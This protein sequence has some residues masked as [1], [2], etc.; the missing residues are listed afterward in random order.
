MLGDMLSGSG[1]RRSSGTDFDDL[2]I[3]IAAKI[4]LLAYTE[5]ARRRL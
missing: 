1:K 3:L 2:T 5:P 4:L